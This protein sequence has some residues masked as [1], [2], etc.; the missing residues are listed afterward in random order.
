MT[1]LVVAT[2]GVGVGV[3]TLGVGGGAVVGSGVRSATGLGRA[4][5]VVVV[6]E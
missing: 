5:V 1:G 2:L 6:D 3:A 4:V